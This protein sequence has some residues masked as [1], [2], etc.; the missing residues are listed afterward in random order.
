MTVLVFKTNLI[1]S[2]LGRLLCPK[3]HWLTGV[4]WSIDWEDCDRVL[5]IEA[6]TVPA[7]TI[8]DDLRG[9][10]IDCEELR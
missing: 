6:P 3:P 10:G 8:E 4:R 7:A 9:K 2:D 5:R 1:P